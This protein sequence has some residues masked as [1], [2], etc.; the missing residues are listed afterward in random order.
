ME[1]GWCREE[2]GGG[3]GA[4]GGAGGGS[5]QESMLAAHISTPGLYQCFN[6]MYGWAVDGGGGTGQATTATT[7]TSA[8][9]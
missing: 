6:M 5:I 2:G 9:Q 7:T 1:S 8:Y 4:V 3:G